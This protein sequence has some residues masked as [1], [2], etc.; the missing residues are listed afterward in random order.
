MAT[1]IF[2]KFAPATEITTTTPL[3]SNRL[4]RRGVGVGFAGRLAARGE[5]FVFAARQQ[6][7][8]V[9]VEGCD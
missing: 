8:I 4:Y 2:E 3:R 9:C 7:E 1:A 6:H 5:L